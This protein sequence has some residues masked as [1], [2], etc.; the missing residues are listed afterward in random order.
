MSLGEKPGQWPHAVRLHTLGGGLKRQMNL[1][2]AGD[3]LGSSGCKADKNGNGKTESAK[4]GSQKCRM[5]SFI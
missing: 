4:K 2:E 3:V 1:R 5:F